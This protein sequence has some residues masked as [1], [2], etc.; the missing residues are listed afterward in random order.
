MRGFV[1]KLKPS[2]LEEGFLLSSAAS[3]SAKIWKTVNDKRG[4]MSDNDVDGK[5]DNHESVSE[6]RKA[7]CC[8]KEEEYPH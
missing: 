4:D 8:V 6:W 7:F 5:Q 3:L 2:S 1:D